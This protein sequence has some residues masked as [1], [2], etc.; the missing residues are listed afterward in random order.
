ME[1]QKGDEMKDPLSE[2]ELFLR[3]VKNFWNF[4]ETKHEDGEWS[5]YDKGVNLIVAVKP[6]ESQFYKHEYQVRII[7]RMND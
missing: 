5:Y 3:F 7:D 1:Y 2:K 4:T 6:V